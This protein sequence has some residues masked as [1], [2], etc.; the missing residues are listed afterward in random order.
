MSLDDPDPRRQY[1]CLACEDT[2]A[3]FHTECPSCGGQ[4]FRT[5]ARKPD[6]TPT[7]PIQRVALA[8]APL[9][10]YVPR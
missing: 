1:T 5:A 6:S 9:N 3:Q 2:L 8:T 4:S 10:P 7:T